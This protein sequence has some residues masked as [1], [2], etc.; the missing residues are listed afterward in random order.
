MEYSN[1]IGNLKQLLVEKAY[2]KLI[3]QLKSELNNT[4]PAYNKLIHIEQTYGF[5]KQQKLLGRDRVYNSQISKINSDLFTLICELTKQEVNRQ[6]KRARRSEPVSNTYQ[7]PTPVIDEVEEQIY[8]QT[9]PSFNTSSNQTT[10]KS[11]KKG[12][13]KQLIFLLA[14]T[15]LAIIGIDYSD[16]LEQQPQ[17]SPMNSVSC[18]ESLQEI[19]HKVKSSIEDDQ[20][21]DAIKTLKTFEAL[22]HENEE[23]I[24]LLNSRVVR[25]K[26]E[27]RKGLISQKDYDRAKNNINSSILDFLKELSCD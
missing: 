23:E 24:I 13:W 4:S 2:D 21:I 12:K 6:F 22:S 14:I 15:L 25:V 10:Q 26:G 11:S 19:S 1:Y 16:V 3:E 18:M 20:S 5:L 8:S 9:G 7:E 17:P 27:K